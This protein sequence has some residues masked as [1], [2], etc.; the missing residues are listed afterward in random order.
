[1]CSMGNIDDNYV[2]ILY[3][4]EGNWT[5]HGGHFVMYIPVKS[6]CYKLK[7]NIISHINYTSMKISLP[8]PK[9]RVQIIA[10]PLLP[11]FSPLF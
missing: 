3:V 11:C 6:L 7:T 8:F 9:F 4:T 10:Y 1:M 5:Y 2:L